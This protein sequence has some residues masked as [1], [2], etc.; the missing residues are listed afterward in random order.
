MTG[1]SMVWRLTIDLR[2]CNPKRFSDKKRDQVLFD[3][4]LFGRVLLCK[5]MV[6]AVNMMVNKISAAISP[7]TGK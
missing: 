2:D 7:G 1:T 3:H 6:P 4:I 5:Y